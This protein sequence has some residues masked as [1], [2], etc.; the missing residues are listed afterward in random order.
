MLNQLS[1]LDYVPTP[2]EMQ[3]PAIA[4]QAPEPIAP[5]ST[6]NQHAIAWHEA[7]AAYLLSMIARFMA[8]TLCDRAIRQHEITRLH[9]LRQQALQRVKELGG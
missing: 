7:K 9:Q 1:L 3:P 2:E 8:G 6:A 5:P 4:E